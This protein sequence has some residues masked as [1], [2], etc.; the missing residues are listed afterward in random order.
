MAAELSFLRFQNDLWDLVI[1]HGKQNGDFMAS[2]VCADKIRKKIGSGG[3]VKKSL[4][5]K[6]IDVMTRFESVD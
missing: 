2:C 5:Y 3:R 6:I 1:N 4:R